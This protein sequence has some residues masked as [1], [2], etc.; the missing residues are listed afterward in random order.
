MHA[1]AP[2][3]FYTAPWV[4]ESQFIPGLTPDVGEWSGE[5][6]QLL[7]HL[8]VQKS[9]CVVNLSC[10]ALQLVHLTANLHGHGT[11]RTE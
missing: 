4:G 8:K 11:E 5:V 6:L 10:T 1:T 7:L 9:A 2:K 3:Q